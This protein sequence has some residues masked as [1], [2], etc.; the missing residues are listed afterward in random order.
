MA[1]QSRLTG[2]GTV[3]ALQRYPPIV[4]LLMG[5]IANSA[6]TASESL[7]FF[8][9][10][11]R[12]VLVE[13][14]YECHSSG[15]ATPDGNLRVD[16]RQGLLDGGDSGPAIVAGQPDRSLLLDALRYESLQMPPAG[17]LADDVIADFERWIG[18]GAVD[19]R[20][21]PQSVSE[22]N[23]AAW[24]A[25]LAQ[26][27]HWW[28]LQSPQGHSPPPSNAS[29]WPIDSVDQF[30]AAK[31]SDAAIKPS[32]PAD[33][34]TLLRRLSFVLNGLPPQPEQVT[35][36][37]KR[38]AEDADAATIAL[39]DQLLDSPHFGERFARHWMDVVRYTDTY[40]YEWDNPAKGSWE[41]RDYLIRAFN[42]DVG[43]DQ[44]IREQIAGD[45][46]AD[47]RIDPTNGVNES[48]IGPMFYHMG[49]HRHGTSLDFN[50][51]HQEMIDNKIDVF[52]KAF[53]S[54][55]VACARCHDH[56]LD[57]ISQADY[58]ALAGVFMSPRW[59]PRDIATE[60]TDADA[61]AELKRLR[62]QIHRQVARHWKAHVD[63]ATFHSGALMQW[64]TQNASRLAATS[65]EDVGYPL[66][67][68]LE[69]AAWIE[70]QKIVARATSESTQLIVEPLG[71]ILAVG[72]V[73]QSDTYTIEFTTGPG[74]IDQL[75]LEALT[76]P[77]LG[78][79][80]PGRTAH[81]NFVLSHIQVE[82]KPLGLAAPIVESTQDASSND[83]QPVPVQDLK[84]VKLA[85]AS[86]D[87]SQA[88]YPVAAALDPSPR[89]G[90][91]IGGTIP[92]NV[93]RTARFAF[94]AP[95][96]LSH[97]GV[98][99]VT[100]ANQYGSEHILGYFRITLGGQPVATGSDATGSDA[101]RRA[102]DARIVARWQQLAGD[103][104]AERQR[105][106]QSNADRFQILSDFSTPD[107]SADW[108]IDGLGMTHG[109]VS[110]GTLQVALQGDTV[111]QTI[112]PRGYHSGALS[113][114]LAGAIRL[115]A[116]Q[117]FP[118]KLVSLRLAGGDWAGRIDVP[119]N[120][121][122]AEEVSFFDPQSTA[123]WHSVGPRGLKNG[124]TRVLTE[125][126]TASLH[127]NFP[128]RTGLA[129]SGATKLPD[130][131]NGLYKRSWMSVTGIVAHDD[132]GVPVDTLDAFAAL[133]ESAAPDS[134]DQSWEHLR[135]WL[136]ASVRRWA[137]SEA[138]ATDVRVLNWLLAEGLLPNDAQS[139]VE[140]ASL[141]KRY[142]EIESTIGYARSVMSMDER[143]LE[144]IHYRLN[145]R[146]DVD[147]EGE[148]VP[149][150]F[151]EVFAGQHQ[152]DGAT[153]SAR[154]ELAKYLASGKQPQTA[155]VY[156]NRI[157]QSVFGTGLVATPNDFGKLGDQP[158][159]PELLDWLA[160]G[161]IDDGWSTKKLLRRLVL[162]RTFCQSGS[163]DP[164]AAERDPDNRLLH[165]YP[166]RRLEGEAIR[167]SLLA[168]AGHLNRS[169][170]GPPI[171]P[172]RVA[173]DSAKRLFS[174]P[175]DG[176]GRRS[177]YTTLSI[178]EPPKFL[179]GFN[180]PDL[181][182]PTGR[183]DQ[184]NV[185]AQ[186]L[187]LLNSPFVTQLAERWATSLMQ[188]MSTDPGERVDKLFLAALGRLP[189]ERERQRWCD[190]V[191]ADCPPASN[192]MSD[193]QAWTQLAHAMFNTK[194][195]IYYR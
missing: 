147:N 46:L 23:E 11:I 22:A 180:L 155:R 53:L 37:E 131:D 17:K 160:I 151:L 75:Q 20:Q 179:V 48:L 6:V 175:W 112:L 168:T 159:H 128:P 162:S 164:I 135:Q 143:A 93:N 149:Q 21:Q 13:H 183:R 113:T 89:N 166:T 107:F 95:V 100:L 186:S 146:G 116:P 41:Y 124:V 185:P 114:K 52:S 174:G 139:I 156:V 39:V 84:I 169:L 103:W 110:D 121:F 126:S 79:G 104:S 31:Q 188:D 7:S 69:S 30:I 184:T 32:P 49:E 194:E 60:V 63:S 141:V 33:A 47:P 125:F 137:D 140:V 2:I 40:G 12:P 72:E 9:L 122:Q 120:A 138:T 152:V 44:L 108:A 165:H 42:D 86:A 80:G 90:W 34:Q 134:V 190:A 97:G 81:G 132:A 92:L 191:I 85:S 78:G 129:K 8:E 64:A 153:S 76:H 70:P 45:L 87:F 77:S 74:T 142:R 62:N 177:I 18:E 117:S 123:T 43:F 94:A 58:Y 170:Y 163:V 24:R 187:I 10:R 150:G 171:N 157:W 27:R 105:R 19:P 158:S 29:D 55:T 65:I 130:T 15:V 178:M 102:A 118:K 98:W 181:K 101:M 4:A 88:G 161:F 172:P 50:G 73:P 167:D 28:S 68:L 193:H 176:N 57:A 182:L 3:C 173:E 36:F 35:A 154:L 133:Y 25:K 54:M 56:K 145:I 109:Y 16:F 106:R 51:I 38:F 66:G 195:F 67:Q 26:R 96:E 61:I 136:A 83:A 91:G 71:S 148:A 5:L 115:P 189:S 82:V 144:P 1:G 14:C 59:T 127:P 192:V 119:Q 111:I 99:K